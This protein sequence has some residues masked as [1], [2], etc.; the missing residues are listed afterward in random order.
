MAACL[1][2]L[3]PTIHN[4]FLL[5]DDDVH[6]S[7]NHLI[8]SV[9]IANIQQIFT[10]N[11]NGTY[12][13]LTILS[14]ALDHY[15]FNGQA[16]GFHLVNLIL[17]L[18]LV[19]LIYRFTLQLGYSRLT[20]FF[21][22]LIF[23]MHPLHVE[24]VA[25][26]TARKDV[27]YALLYVAALISYVR[28]SEEGKIKNYFFACGFGLLSILAKPMALSLPLILFL[29]DWLK[30]RPLEKKTIIEKVPFFLYVIPIALLT[31]LPNARWPVQ[32]NIGESMLIWIYTFSFYL[33]KFFVPFPLNPLYTLPAPISLFTWPYSAAAA[34]FCFCVVSLWIF[35]RQRLFIFALFFYFLSNFFLF[36]FDVGRDLSIVADRFMY[37]SSFGLCLLAGNFLDNR[38]SAASRAQYRIAPAIII[39]LFLLLGSMTFT[40]SIYWRDNE[41]LWTR[42]IVLNPRNAHAYNN[43]GIAYEHAGHEDRALADYTQAIQINPYHA[44]ALY[45]RG[46]IYLRRGLLAQAKQDFDESYSVRPD[47]EKTLYSLGQYSLKINDSTGA[48]DYFNRVLTFNP[49]QVEA[50]VSR[51]NIYKLWGQRDKALT[52]LNHAIEVSPSSARLYNN[53]AVLY[54]DREEWP[55]AV[56]DINQALELDPQLGIAYNNR[57][58]V[59]NAQGDFVRAIEAYSQALAIDR[60]PEFFYNRANVYLKKQEPESAV[61]DY[62][63]AIRIDNHYYQAYI[64]RSLAYM[65]LKQYDLALSDANQLLATGQSAALGYYNRSKIYSLRHDYANALADALKAQELGRDIEKE[66]IDELKEKL[67]EY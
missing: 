46:N 12:I 6:I 8:Q 5:W 62:D 39:V 61:I 9:S 3:I 66:Y 30:R 26:A 11:V 64:N 44:K 41:N 53:R 10:T 24:P 60:Q 19:V 31:Y 16:W 43:R 54:M 15:F 32:T 65:M 57:G 27:L 37:L 49:K 56:S 22:A 59:Y 45:N 63:N 55:R 17:H 7:E 42:V 33:I 13:P 21:S 29:L 50:L 4:N 1:V 20:A 34:I 67:G 58:I 2:S 47:D 18:V 40:Q 23:G 52:D 48:L 25:W 36:R 35:R 14:F 38:L 51:S 28:Y